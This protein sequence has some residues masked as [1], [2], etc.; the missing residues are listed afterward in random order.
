[1]CA[2]S[3]SRSV[4]SRPGVLAVWR[5]RLVQELDVLGADQRPRRRQRRPRHRALELADVARPVV[6]QQPFGGLG[7]QLLGV[8]R[9]AVGGAVAA[10]EPRR[11]HRDVHRPLLERR[12]PD[13]EGVHPVE[14]VLA[15]AALAHELVERAVG[16]RDQPEVD[17]DRLAAAQPLE[18]ALFEDAQDLGLRHQRQVADLVE[19]EGAAVGQLEPARLALVRAGE[20]ALLVAEDLR[21]EQRVGQRGA[22]HR[23]ELL[24]AAPRQ[25]VDHPRHHFLAGA[26]RPEDEHRDVRLG[27]G[28][29][30]LEDGQH[31][32]VA[33]DQLAEPL[34]R[35]RGVLDADRGAA[36]EEG[37]EQLAQ[38]RGGVEPGGRV[39]HRVAG[40]PADDARL[41]QLLE[42]VLDVEAHPPEGLHDGLGIELLAGRALR[43]RRIPARSGDWTSALNRA[44]GSL[45]DRGAALDARL[46]AN[47]R[48]S[49]AV[50]SRVLVSDT[51]PQ[52]G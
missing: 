50:Y 42:A 49:T 33:A 1:M 37:V 19:E 23:L 20:G 6:A 36:F 40:D 27:G 7:R 34:H 18:A 12:Q 2:R 44:S 16:G 21:F 48:S 4:G 52:E 17:V 10:D 31:L 28:A 35:G 47:E 32:L 45:S 5:Q 43:K 39:G 25:L 51:P 26:G 38:G 15:E 46:A 9:Q 11:Q 22:V 14:Q 13:R 3:L 8:E 24:G 29:D 30:P 41:D